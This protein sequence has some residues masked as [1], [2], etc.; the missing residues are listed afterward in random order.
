MYAEVKNEIRSHKEDMNIPLEAEHQEQH[1]MKLLFLDDGH[2]E[3]QHALVII[4]QSTEQSH[5]ISYCKQQ[6]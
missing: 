6:V 3:L 5:L 4:R 2:L 1:V